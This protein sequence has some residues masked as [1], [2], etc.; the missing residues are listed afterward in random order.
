M[1]D[2]GETRNIRD[3]ECMWRGRGRGR[4]SLQADVVGKIL[5]SKQ[6]LQLNSDSVSKS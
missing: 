6:L 5:V 1:R 3:R 4:G 2:V